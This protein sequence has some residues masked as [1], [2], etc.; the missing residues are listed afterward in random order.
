M[1]FDIGRFNKI[2]LFLYK[3]RPMAFCIDLEKRLLKC[4]YNTSWKSIPF[5][6]LDEKGVL[7]PS[8]INPWVVFR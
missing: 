5:V 3:F 8:L 1:C 4:I 6:P 2:G 7:L